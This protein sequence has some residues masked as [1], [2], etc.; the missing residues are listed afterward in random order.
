TTYNLGD[1]QL[2]NAAPIAAGDTLT[3][4]NNLWGNLRIGD[5]QTGNYLLSGTVQ[6][7][8]DVTGNI[9]FTGRTDITG[10]IDIGGSLAEGA[11]IDYSPGNGRYWLADIVVAGDW[12]G[13]LDVNGTNTRLWETGGDSWDIDIAGNFGSPTITGTLFDVEDAQLRTQSWNRGLRVGTDGTGIMYADRYVHYITIG[14]QTPWYSA[15]RIGTAASGNGDAYMAH[16]ARVVS[17]RYMDSRVYIYGGGNPEAMQ[18]QVLVLNPLG[19]GMAMGPSSGIYV[20]NGGM[21]DQGEYRALNGPS[22]PTPD[23][24]GRGAFGGGGRIEG[25]MAGAMAVGDGYTG[26][27]SEDLAAFGYNF[28]FT[29]TGDMTGVI[30]TFGRGTFV[31]P[32]FQGIM[33]YGNLDL[34]GDVTGDILGYY[35]PDVELYT[36]GTTFSGTIE[37]FESWRGGALRIAGTN[38]GTIRGGGED[39]TLTQGT[40]AAGGNTLT[41]NTAGGGVLTMTSNTTAVPYSYLYSGVGNTIEALRVEGNNAVQTVLGSGVVLNS[42]WS[43]GTING[44]GDPRIDLDDNVGLGLDSALHSVTL[45]RFESGRIEV[46]GEFGQMLLPYGNFGGDLLTQVGPVGT[47]ADLS[48]IIFLREYRDYLAGH[49]V[50]IGGDIRQNAGFYS[51]GWYSTDT[52]AGFNIDV[53]GDMEGLMIFPDGINGDITIG[54]DLASNARILTQRSAGQIGGTVDIGGDLAGY[55]YIGNGT[56]DTNANLVGAINVGGDITDTGR[57][58]IYGSQG[59]TNTGSVNVTGSILRNGGAYGRIY[60]FQGPMD[61]T[62]DVT[63]NNAGYISIGDGTSDTNANVTGLIH[64]GGDMLSAAGASRV[65]VYGTGG[66]TATGQIDIDGGMVGDNSRIYVY[67]GPLAGDITVGG[68]MGGRIYIGDGNAA[69][70][71]NLSGSLNITNVASDPDVT[72]YIYVYGTG[73]ITNTGTV[74][75]DGDIAVDR[76]L[77]AYEGPIAGTVT[78]GGNLIGRIQAGDSEADDATSDISGTINIGGDLGGDNDSRIRAYGTG[79]FT[80]TSVVNIGGS[81]TDLGGGNRGAIITYR[82]PIEGVINVGGDM[83]G[84]IWAGNGAGDTTGNITGTIN[85]TNVASDPGLVGTGEIYAYG[86][87]GI[88][89]DINIDGNLADTSRIYAPGAGA[90]LTGAVSIGGNIQDGAYIEVNDDLGGTGSITVTGD[91]TSNHAGGAIDFGGD[92]TSAAAY[93]LSVGGRLDA[94]SSIDFGG[95]ASTGAEMRF[96]GEFDGLVRV[97][98]AGAGVFGDVKVAP[99]AGSTGILQAWN[100]NNSAFL[101]T[102]ATT[103]TQ[104]TY[105]RD[106]DSA[107]NNDFNTLFGGRGLLPGSTLTFVDDDGDTVQIAYNGDPGSSVDVDLVAAGLGFNITTLDYNGATANSALDVTILNVVGNGATTA[108]NVTATGQVFGSFSVDGWIES[109]TGG[110]L[111]AGETVTTT[112]VLGDLTG[113]MALE[114]DLA[115]QVTLSGDLSGSI[116]VPGDITTVGDYSISVAGNLPAAGSI[117]VQGDASAGAEIRVLGEFDGLIQV[118]AGGAG[119][120]G[121]VKIAPNVGS[122]GTLRAWGDNNAASLYTD[123]VTASQLTFIRDSAPAAHAWWAMNDGAGAV[124]TDSS[125][126]GNDGNLLNMEPGDWVPGKF[127]TALQF[128]GVNEEVNAGNDPSLQL[129]GDLTVAFWLNP[130]LLTTTRDNPIDKSYGGEFA[131]TIERNSGNISYYHGQARAAGQYWSWQPFSG[132]VAGE[133]QFFV[134]TREQATRAMASYYNGDLFRTTTYSNDPA[135]LPSTSTYDVRIGDGY[136][137]NYNGMIDDVHIYAAQLTADEVWQLYTGTGNLGTNNDFN[138]LFGD[139]GARLDP[140]E[141]MVLTDVDGDEVTITYNG[142]AGS[143]VVID[144]TPAG[145]GVTIDRIAYGA[146]TANSDLNVS[147]TTVVGD[148]V[149]DVDR[150]DATGQT[151][152]TFFLDGAVSDW[153]GGALAGGE[154]FTADDV[155]DA[156]WL[157]NDLG[158]TLT[159]TG[160]LTGGINVVGDVLAGGLIDIGVGVLG[161]G[162]FL[163]GGDNFGTINV[164]GVAQNYVGA[165]LHGGRNV[166][167]V[168]EDPDPS[169]SFSISAANDLQ[170]FWDGVHDA[171][172]GVLYNGGTVSALYA[173]NHIDSVVSNGLD[174]NSIGV[175]GRVKAVSDII[176]D[177]GTEVSTGI[178]IDVTA[179]NVAYLRMNKFD[180][181][182]YT[183][184]IDG[185]LGTV[186]IREGMLEGTIRTINGGSLTGDIITA[187]GQEIRGRIE[188]DGGLSGRIMPGGT[189]TPTTGEDIS[190]QIV[191]NGNMTGEIYAY[192]LGKDVD[193]GYDSAGNPQV[194][195][196]KGSITVGGNITGLIDITNAMMDYSFINATGAIASYNGAQGIRIQ[197]LAGTGALAGRIRTAIDL[198]N[199]ISWSI[200]DDVDASTRTFTLGDQNLVT[201]AWL[202]LDG[203]NIG[204]GWAIE[205]PTIE[206]QNAVTLA[207]LNGVLS[208]IIYDGT[209]HAGTPL[210]SVSN[211]TLSDFTTAG[212]GT[213]TV[214]NAGNLDITAEALGAGD[215]LDIRNVVWGRVD[216]GAN[217]MNGL[218]DVGGNLVYDADNGSDGWIY[219]TGRIA[220]FTGAAGIR[221]QGLAAGSGVMGGRITTALDTPNLSVANTFVIGDDA[222]AGT[223]ALSI[224]V[225]GG[226]GAQ[227]RLMLDG[228]FYNI[229]DAWA[230]ESPTLEKYGGAL[231][232]AQWTSIQ[233]AAG[234]TYDGAAANGGLS[235]SATQASPVQFT[236]LTADL[237]MYNLGGYVEIGGDPS[238]PNGRT[239]TVANTL[240]GD[241]TVGTYG[242]NNL[243]VQ[244]GGTIDIGKDLLG[245]IN[246]VAQMNMIDSGGLK[247]STISIGR[248]FAEGAE[249]DYTPFV[250]DDFQGDITVGGDWVGVFDI[251]GYDMPGNRG[252]DIFYTGTLAGERRG[253]KITVNG[254]FGAPT[255]TGSL[256]DIEGGRIY[257]TSSIPTSTETGFWI[258]NDGTGIMYGDI[259]VHI[260]GNDTWGGFGQAYIR[261]MEIGTGASTAGDAYMAHT[262]RM[263]ADRY[264]YHYYFRIHGANQPDAFRGQFLGG[265]SPYAVNWSSIGIGGYSYIYGG[266]DEQAEIRALRGPYRYAYTSWLDGAMPFQITFR[267]D[268]EGV[269][270]AGDGYAKN[271]WGAPYNMMPAETYC[272]FGR[273]AYVNVANGGDFSGIIRSF[274]RDHEVAGEK[275][276]SFHNLEVDIAGKMSGDILGFYVSDIEMDGDFTGRIEAFDGFKAGG[277]RLAGAENGT[278]RAGGTDLNYTQGA[279]A[280]GATFNQ[281]FGGGSLSVTADPGNASAMT[282]SYLYSGAGEHIEAFRTDNNTLNV[283]SVVGTGVTMSSLAIEGRLTPGTGLVD[284]ND[285]G[286]LDSG[287]G[288]VWLRYFDGG[289]S[290]EVEGDLGQVLILYNNFDG[291]ITTTDG[292][293]LV[294]VIHTK[295][296]TNFTGGSVTIDGDMLE[297]SGVMAYYEMRAPFA[298]NVAGDMN[299][300]ISSY[301]GNAATINVG[302]SVNR[303]GTILTYYHG[304]PTLGGDLAGTVTVT[305]DWGG[306]IRCGMSTSYLNAITGTI[307]IGGQITNTGYIW[308]YSRGGI[309]ATGAINIG[310]I[311]GGGIASGGYIRTFRGAMDGTINVWGDVNGS[312]IRVGENTSGSYTASDLTG[313]IT[314]N[315]DLP[316][317]IWV[318][319]SQGITGTGSITVNGD[320]RSGGYILVGRAGADVAGS[321]TIANNIQDTAYIRIADDVLGTGQINVGGNVTSTQGAGAIDINGDLTGTVDVTG[322]IDNGASANDEVQI[323]GNLSGSLL[324]A[325]FGDVT[326][327]GSF[328]GTIG[329][330]TTSAGV[331]NTLTVGVAGGGGSL[332]PN[333]LIFATRIGYP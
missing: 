122:I 133:W 41:I 260:P 22:S 53:A 36:G 153:S 329:R 297:N 293:N 67:R 162:V 196:L 34:G 176:Y 52:Q 199:P 65:Q 296:G 163:D 206:I 37:A 85:I 125:T 128:D 100:D 127:G 245:N 164:G 184:Q 79:G 267:N 49:S 75:I 201:N 228:R 102:D 35:I 251:N 212:A 73:G 93:S 321:I 78:V 232:N 197:G 140:G 255:V 107:S 291:N 178:G 27:G 161:G 198:D 309:G 332:V 253:T 42:F 151:F 123:T 62:I 302:G 213:L 248:N 135:K 105:N 219:S 288:S 12:L 191:V 209:G 80:P 33:S 5:A 61:G 180:H 63:G 317:S 145:L 303:W 11:T 13:V 81:I 269:I 95:D 298:L 244:G 7:G 281:A 300:V 39:L 156:M 66:V 15:V 314:I 124:A 57:L 108:G 310:T 274:G 44:G 234:L 299:G 152:G 257:L 323:A 120:F 190:G 261:R 258:G 69:T 48:G 286:V 17:D 91:V 46:E 89:G 148:G 289:E 137:H 236:A 246:L 266:M 82:G 103:S 174:F 83:A 262:A 56:N 192:D 264:L 20:Y 14:G 307:N 84:S 106:F 2:T 322:N 320:L 333:D 113:L 114:G 96:L 97:G 43:E 111:V 76:W 51:A 8:G 280:A 186:V 6:V 304:G 101:I 240:W 231:T 229:G 55:I 170:V 172:V 205:S 21:S 224:P 31:G 60:T 26:S 131:F 328:S 222:A 207:Q 218:I 279:L 9:D 3:I 134:V 294:G 223:R 16:T 185:D 90:D 59:I 118:G 283:S 230:Y 45:G 71:A 233:G 169:V 144:T 24:I 263:L 276:G 38:A 94:A 130:A 175:D 195:P 143:S 70:G 315:G 50:Q 74:T 30:R 318:Y 221:V 47:N 104:L 166:T 19:Q 287:L 189:T 249:I 87:S 241:L 252:T 227:F 292:G 312:A 282:Y 265:T 250:D 68:D 167:G 220:D 115:G 158:G 327:G 216:L 203:R 215:L 10:L 268:M 325:L 226:V 139:S 278:I 239:F 306:L 259:D 72:G 40:L 1:L 141:S 18:G 305:G 238:I 284:F 110:Q 136:S 99:H 77:I 58:Y 194:W 313:S 183:V 217:A 273:W 210:A 23:A 311:T 159:I 308:T 179:G 242:D 88:S 126:Y 92:V 177:S 29:V 109:W 117:V 116:T 187:T 319:G 243:S 181:P 214:L 28:N 98:S 182:D 301:Y 160:P 200:G 202:T 154:T 285:S 270:A 54:G 235:L 86:T 316:G 331:G 295:S 188:I 256:I 150:V 129:D 277:V 112:G 165:P 142:D 326:I 168:A 211:V 254:N 132:I 171:G 193:N 121:D 208:G 247:R 271:D 146:A 237:T 272:N 4:T 225:V 173:N 25:T 147:V 155:T 275:Q 149:V 64:I 138:T 324:A 157:D 119:A 204:G 330:P 290:I 32:E